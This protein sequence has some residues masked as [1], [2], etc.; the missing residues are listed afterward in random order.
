MKTTP[1]VYIIE[2]LYPGDEGNGRLEGVFLAQMLRLHGKETK[3]SYVRTRS[4]FK[5]A[6]R[7]FKASGYRY[8]HISAH[9]NA[10]GIDTTNQE[11]ITYQTL[12]RLLTGI[13]HNCR[14][15]MSSCE[16]VHERSAQSLV[17]EDRFRSLLGPRNRIKFHD[18]AATWTAIYHLLFKASP[19][20]MADSRLT[21]TVESLTELFGLNFA[22]FTR[23][24][25]GEIEDRLACE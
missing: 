18:S 3:Y 4:E 6:V 15:F 24:D 22:F 20:S 10:E 8:L 14:L 16:V 12:A 9:G 11:G 17:S 2:S 1:N 21:S 5:A 23:T 7:D 19:S 13:S 25:E